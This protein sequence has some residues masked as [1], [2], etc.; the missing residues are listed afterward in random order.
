MLKYISFAY[1]LTPAQVSLLDPQLP[2]NW[3]AF[4]Q[5]DIQARASADTTK[6]QVRLIVQSLLAERIKL[7]AHWE[8]RHIPKSG[9]RSE[10]SS[11]IT[12]RNLH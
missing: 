12:S 3:V 5:F 9:T 8:V 4:D 11:S 2:G 7:A 6:D 1:K 10:P